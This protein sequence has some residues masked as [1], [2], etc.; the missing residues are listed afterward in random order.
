LR[1]RRAALASADDVPD[2][3]PGARQCRW[4]PRPERLIGC[5]GVVAA[6]ALWSRPMSRWSGTRD[7]TTLLGVL[8]AAALFR[9][10]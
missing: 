2:R 3:A 10:D 5:C 4:A 9:L 8:A 7:L 1:V 6:P